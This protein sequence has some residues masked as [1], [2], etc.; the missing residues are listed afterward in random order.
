MNV[1]LIVTNH[2]GDYKR[3]DQIID[4]ATIKAILATSNAAN[5]VKVPA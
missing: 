2:F 5:V 1:K 4:P 3:G